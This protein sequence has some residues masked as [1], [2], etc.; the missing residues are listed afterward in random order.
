MET[1]RAHFADRY[2]YICIRQHGNRAPSSDYGLADEFRVR[3][4]V[5]AEKNY[6]LALKRA[7]RNVDKSF[8]Q[9]IMDNYR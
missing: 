7:A 5:D 3:R 9:R 4:G 6:G 8:S 1:Y 2:I